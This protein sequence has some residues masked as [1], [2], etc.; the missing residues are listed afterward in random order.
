M[1][2]GTTRRQSRPAVRPGGGGSGSGSSSRSRSS[3]SSSRSRSGGGMGSSGG[4]TSSSAGS[5]L[6]HSP[7]RRGRSSC[8]CAAR[9]PT[10]AGR[11]SC[12]AG[13]HLTRA[14]CPERWAGAARG[15]RAPSAWDRKRRAARSAPTTAGRAASAP[16]PTS[17]WSQCRILCAGFRS[18]EPGR[19]ARAARPAPGARAA[20]GTRR[21]CAS[22]S[23]SPWWVVGALPFDR[24][25]PQWSSSVSLQ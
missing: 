24:A 2:G 22:T 6:A 7:C 23:G 15:R 17:R 8:C 19:R 12:A 11:S 13:G 18:P 21:R 10:S 14:C 5:R 25:L 1:V 3:S 16:A 20:R 4:G 9:P